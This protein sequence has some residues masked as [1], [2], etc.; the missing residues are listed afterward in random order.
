MK[1]ANTR[2]K[3]SISASSFAGV[4]GVLK[5]NPEFGNAV[6]IDGLRGKN[7]VP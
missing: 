1:F 6:E 7:G 2:R 5:T 4:L 3:V